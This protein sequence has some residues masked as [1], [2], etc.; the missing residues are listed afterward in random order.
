MSS[1]IHQRYNKKPKR[2]CYFVT[3]TK[4]ELKGIALSEFLLKKA[5]KTWDDV[6]EPRASLEDI[7]IAAI[8]AFKKGAVSS[9][10]LPFI[11]SEND[12]EQIL[13]NL[14][15]LENKQLKRS[16][17]LLFSKNPCR[18]YINAYVKIG[19]F[20]KS[21]DDLK[22]QEVVESNAYELANKTLEVLA[23]IKPDPRV[24]ETLPVA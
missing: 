18:Y 20:G 12:I 14:L 16:A 8:E 6:V 5:G 24:P 9:K 10:R 3:I 1:S 22:F 19:R 17:V 2:S 23:P 11:E 7:D 13:D 21:D 15:L 4:Q